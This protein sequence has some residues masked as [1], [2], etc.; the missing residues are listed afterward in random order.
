MNASNNIPG[1]RSLE[2]SDDHQNVEPGI[3]ADEITT[4]HH[5]GDSGIDKLS[6]YDKQDSKPDPMAGKNKRNSDE[7]MPARRRV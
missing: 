5:D 6:E 3:D 2:H 7:A 4:P 1:G